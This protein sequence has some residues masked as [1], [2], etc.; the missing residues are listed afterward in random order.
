ML[1]CPSP[2]SSTPPSESIAERADPKSPWPADALR[3]ATLDSARALG[4]ES[5][6]GSIDAGKV[7]DLA[8]LDRCPLEDPTV[9]GEPVAAL[10]KGGSLAIDRCQ[11]AG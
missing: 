1:C 10:F 3:A 2:T 11:L 7:A 9:L 8:I 4:V 6:F 5:R